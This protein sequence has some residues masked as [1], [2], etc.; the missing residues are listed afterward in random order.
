MARERKPS[1]QA[2]ERSRA[3]E[4]EKQA[5]LRGDYVTPQE[6]EAYKLRQQELFDAVFGINDTALHAIITRL[7]GLNEVAINKLEWPG[8]ASSHREDMKRDIVKRCDLAFYIVANW[9]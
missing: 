1:K 9:V 6:E 8:Y 7:H 4:A 5:I 2:I 3:L